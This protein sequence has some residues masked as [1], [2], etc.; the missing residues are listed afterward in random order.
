MKNINI[1]HLIVKN[2]S[3]Y[4][5]AAGAAVC[6]AFAIGKVIRITK[7][8]RTKEIA[9]R[10]FYLKLLDYI[11]DLENNFIASD[12]NLRIASLASLCSANEVVSTHAYNICLLAEAE[13]K[14]EEDVVLRNIPKNRHL[15]FMATI[16]LAQKGRSG[17][18][19]SNE[20]FLESL[21]YIASEVQ[22]EITKKGR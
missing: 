5:F 10:E 19:R 11:V 3:K 8:V 4:A 1:G 21:D 2:P 7:Y 13:T 16:C 14:N 12:G 9:R 22:G 6:S 15:Q 20:R 18:Y 17:D